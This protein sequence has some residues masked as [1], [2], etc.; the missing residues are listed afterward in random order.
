MVEAGDGSIW[1]TDPTYGIVSDIEGY[2]AEPEQDRNRV[3]R[4]GENGVLT[5]EIDHLVQPNGLCFSLDRTVLFVAD[6]GAERGPELGFDPEGP[7]CIWRFDLR[8]GHVDGRGSVFAE[9]DTGVPDGL[10][11]DG[12]GTI[13]AA[14][15]AGLEAFAQD[16]ARLGIFR[17]PEVASNMCGSLNG[18]Q[19]LVTLATSVWLLSI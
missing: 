5:A 19:M 16:G 11:M 18:R 10:R 13:W 7:R 4:Y 6:S 14:T 2:R 1:F 12:A 15:G 3:Y 17:T 8:G 9:V